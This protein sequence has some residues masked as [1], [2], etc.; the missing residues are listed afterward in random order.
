MDKVDKG[1]IF[2]PQCDT[3]L[4]SNAKFCPRCGLSTEGAPTPKGAAITTTSSPLEPTHVGDT[5]ILGTKWL[6]FWNYF[7]L[8][9]GSVLGLLMSLGMSTS[10]IMV[11]MSILDFVVACG[12]HYRKLWAWKWNWVIIVISYIS[13]IIPTPAPWSQGDADLV[14]QF[15]TKFVVGSLFWMWPNYVYWQKRKGLFT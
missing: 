2:C 3:Q 1:E 13:L 10:I 12:L 8:P 4:V 9:V 11:P 5:K 14:L 15:V 6:K 7:S